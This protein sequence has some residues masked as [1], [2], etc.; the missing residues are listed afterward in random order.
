PHSHVLLAIERN[1]IAE[2]LLLNIAGRTRCDW[3]FIVAR[4]ERDDAYTTDNGE[5]YSP[6]AHIG[7]THGVLVACDTRPSSKSIRSG[8]VRMSLRSVMPCFRFAS[9]RTGVMESRHPSFDENP[10]QTNRSPSFNRRP[11]SKHHS[12]ISSS[13][14]P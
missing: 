5:S 3:S 2:K 13:V 12:S 9:S 7:K 10:F 14:P 6:A 1:P 8:I 11:F 4:G